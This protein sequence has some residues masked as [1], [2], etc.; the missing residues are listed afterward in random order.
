MFQFLGLIIVGTLSW[1]GHID[2]LMFKLGSASYAVRAVKPYM[3]YETMRM[4]YFL[5]FHSIM[6]YGLILWGNLYLQIA[7]E[8]N[9]NYYQ[10]WK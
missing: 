4:V 1:K 5:Y 9:K 10:L 8:A 6:T 7:K 2:R 3:S